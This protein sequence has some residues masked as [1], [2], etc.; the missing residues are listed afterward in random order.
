VLSNWHWYTPLRYLQL[1][2]GWRPDVR[3]T[4][5]YPQGAT[6]MPQAWPQRI[7]EELEG[8][9]RALI[10]TNSYPTYGNLPY[11]FEPLG[12]AFRV[13]PGPS[14]EVP[15][16]ISPLGTNGAGVDL[17]QEEE[18]VLRL[19][20]YRL[21]EAGEIEPGD[22]VTV[23]L[24]WQPLVPL[25]RGYAFFVH[26]VGADGV[27]LGQQDHRHD[28][29]AT[30]E[31][32]EVLTDRYRFP[33]FTTA[34]PGDYRLVAGAY[35]PF[36][37]GTWLRLADEGGQDVFGLDQVSIV[38]ASLPPVTLRPAQVP[39]AHLS[40]DA[41]APA[42][43]GIDFDDSLPEQRR[44]YL[45]WRV[46]D[47]DATAR[48]TAGESVV[49]QSRV[50][51]GRPQEG[52]GRGYVTTALDVPPGTRDLRLELRNAVDE[53]I[54]PRRGVWGVPLPSA[55]PLPRPG[56][57]PEARLRYLP[58]G[59][60]MALVGAETEPARE[61]GQEARVALRFLG[62][63]PIVLDYV[64]SVGVL[65]EAVTDA[66]SDWVPALGAIP[67]FKWIRGSAVNDVHLIRV[68]EGAS[69]AEAT[70]GVYDAFTSASLA[71]LDER[72]ARQGRAGVPLGMRVFD[73]PYDGE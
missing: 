10:V 19:L 32:G 17:W 66:P 51:S 59:G 47:K 53:R 48:L 38:P 37:D 65:G 27:P 25:E 42:L 67:T 29:A 22:Q 34:A 14:F 8:S 1:I 63:R 40:K 68:L 70:L 43:V 45:H 64:V 49:S 7:T 54:L 11:R 26:L 57:G 62:L 3:V 16:R 4:Y 13:L 9:D 61:A 55:L 58:F 12:E 23:D 21:Q 72:I 60:K 69:G 15:A 56:F 6:E 50:P 46:G 52:P 24:F 31:P 28:A 20:G 33:V 71:P 30:Y 41:G 36:E 5:L 39:F 35:L 44:V 2:E 73:S 18:P